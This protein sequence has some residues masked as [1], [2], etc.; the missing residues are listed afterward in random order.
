MTF[1][2]TL[3]TLKIEKGS[4]RLHSLQSSL[5]K[6]LCTCCRTD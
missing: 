6:R 4:N 3:K 2:E 1:K 5:W